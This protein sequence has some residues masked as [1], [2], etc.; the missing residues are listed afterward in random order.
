LKFFSCAGQWVCPRP[1]IYSPPPKARFFNPLLGLFTFL[2]FWTG[3]PE[4]TVARQLSSG[5][6][7]SSKVTYLVFHPTYLLIGVRSQSRVQISN[8]SLLQTVPGPGEDLKSATGPYCRRFPGSTA[9]NQQGVLIADNTQVFVC[10]LFA[11]LPNLP[12]KDAS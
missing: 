8:G 9:L 1:F 5:A 2:N 7:C 3:Q 6:L 11:C 4:L 12:D 10:F